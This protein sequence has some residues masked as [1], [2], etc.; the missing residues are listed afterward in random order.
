MRS[1]KLSVIILA[2][3]V[4]TEPM[5]QYTL[6]FNIKGQINSSSASV[7]V[8]MA[9]GSQ[10]GTVTVKTKNIKEIKRGGTKDF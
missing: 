6:A 4:L 3:A 5:C 7:Q 1:Q 2:T 8:G 9:D 10:N